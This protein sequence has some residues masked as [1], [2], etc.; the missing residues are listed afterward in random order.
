M[1]TGTG[2]RPQ[3]DDR[4]L[5]LPEAEEAAGIDP[6][7]I[8][9]SATQ[10]P[11]ERVAQFLV[12]PKRKCQ[13]AD[14]GKPKELDLE[15]VVPVEDMTE[16]DASIEKRKD[17]GDSGFPPPG[18]AELRRRADDALD[19]AGDLPGAAEARPGA[20]LD[21]HLRQQPPRRGAPGQAAERARQRGAGV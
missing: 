20:Q 5:R 21:D 17:G 18:D 13:I 1:S 19:L 10:R 12:G 8:G 11:L 3:A 7:R 2:P 9:L 6:Q 14:A 16:P 15:I 4:R